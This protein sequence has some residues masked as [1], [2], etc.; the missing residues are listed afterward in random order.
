[1]LKCIG[2]LNHALT[3]QGAEHKKLTE[4]NNMFEALKSR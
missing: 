3:L 1:M 2:K 4:S